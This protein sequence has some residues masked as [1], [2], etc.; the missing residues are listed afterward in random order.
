MKIFDFDI[1]KGIYR[2]ESNGLYTEPHAHPVVEIV[3]ALQGTFSLEC[4]GQQTDGLVFA[5]VDANIAHRLVSENASLGML[6]LESHNGL[7]TEYF[8]AKGLLLDEG[9]CLKTE[10]A[11]RKL[12][13]E[14][15][16]A[17]AV[18]AD[19]KTPTDKRVA[20]CIDHIQTH[21]SEKDPEVKTLAAKVGLSDGRLSHLF[22][23]HIGISIKKYL[24]WD[25]LRRAMYGF[26]DKEGN[27][28]TVSLQGGFFDQAHFSNAFKSVLGIAPSKAYRNSSSLQS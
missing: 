14:A 17:V 25:K 5:I 16:H 18:S 2:F 23:E 10:C 24:V 12:L 20:Q 1:E 13:F 11:E 4:N 6:M 26:L 8:K 27:F 19:L 15:I 21:T 22:K 7:L 3:T 9:C 28:T